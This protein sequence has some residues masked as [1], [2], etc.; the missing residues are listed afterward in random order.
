MTKS[1]TAM[2]MATMPICSNISIMSRPPPSCAKAGVLTNAIA[3][4]A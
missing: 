1:T 3:S 4:P 2:A